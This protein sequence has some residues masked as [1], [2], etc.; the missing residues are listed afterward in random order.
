MKEILGDYQCG[1][2]RRR[3]R[4]DYLFEFSLIMEETDE[5]GIDFY[6]F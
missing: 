1:F 4:T 3:G 5:F 2:R 6:Q